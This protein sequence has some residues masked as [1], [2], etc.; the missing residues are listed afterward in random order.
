M[1]PDIL[2]EVG[3]VLGSVITIVFSLFWARHYGIGK[4]KALLISILS[5]VLG[6]VCIFVLTWIEN[7]FQNFGAQN[8][9]RAYPFLALIA[10]LEAKIFRI[11]FRRSL[12]FQAIATPL[13]YGL[14]HYACL[15]R[16]CCHGFHYQEGTAAYSVAHALTGTDQLPMQIFEATSALILFAIIVIYSYKTRFKVTG[17]AFAIFQILFGFGR[18]FWEFLRDNDKLIVFG[19]MKGAVDLA[20]QQAV[21]GISNLALWAAALFVAGIILFIY[22]KK[23]NKKGETI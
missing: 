23:N 21:W 7:G 20:H 8:G 19:P 11:E 22:L 5:Q 4:V 2:Y 18:F 9:I 17:Y 14:C 3:Q 6:F 15:A 1:T 16:M 12:D 13:S 10:L